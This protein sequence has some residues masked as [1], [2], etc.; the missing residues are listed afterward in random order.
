MSGSGGKIGGEGGK[1]AYRP[2][3]EEEVVPRAA[4]EF[5][6]SFPKF[7]ECPWKP[8]RSCF[9][10]AILALVQA[11]NNPELTKFWDSLTEVFFHNCCHGGHR[12]KGT[13]WK[14]TPQSLPAVCQNDHEHLPYQVHSEN[15]TWSFDTSSE[16]AYLELL[17][18]SVAS[19]SRI[20]WHPKSFL[21]APTQP[22]GSYSGCST[23][24]AQKTPSTYSRIR[25]CSLGA[26]QY[27]H[28][29]ISEDHPFF[30]AGRRFVIEQGS[31]LR[32]IDDGL[33][34]Q[35]NSA[36]S[37]TIRLD[38]QDADYVVALTL[39]LGRT[40]SLL[41]SARRLTC[42]KRASNFPILPTHRDLA[43][44]FFR[45]RHGRTRYYIP[46]AWM[47]G[48]T[49]AVYAFNRVSRSLWFLISVYLKVP[50]AV[51]FDDYPMFSPEQTAQE[52]DTL[53]SDFR[54]L[55]GW[56]HDRTGPK[57]KPFAQSF[58]VLGLTLDLSGLRNNHSVILKTK[59]GESTKYLPRYS[60]LRRWGS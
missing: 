46:D 56:R 10:A 6:R 11:Q 19:A 16:A 36:Y 12:K 15:G 33:E 31:K 51:Y 49:A 32:P 5:A 20:F 34:A 35:L 58:D 9:W 17:T 18:Q 41:G 55:L 2:R 47:F 60:R 27:T 53:V 57:G 7:P 28:H 13:R 21:F 30:S 22:Q 3:L 26:C 45:D 39:E 43:V 25:C 4:L 50:A 38:L 42:Q 37:S 44:T 8:Y 24:T 29:Y 54:D 1:D 23:S 14:S 52:T 40:K 48:S 59:K